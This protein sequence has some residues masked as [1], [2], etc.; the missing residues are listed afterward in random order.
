MHKVEFWSDHVE[1]PKTVFRNLSD[2]SIRKR[3]EEALDNTNGD[4]D[5]W[6]CK[7]DID[8]EKWIEKRFCLTSID[9]ER[10]FEVLDAG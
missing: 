9:G 3:M 6:A 1:P 7:T 10:N 2:D 4:G 8:R 5:V